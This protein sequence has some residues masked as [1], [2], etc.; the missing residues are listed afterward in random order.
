[1]T[2]LNIIGSDFKKRLDLFFAQCIKA[3]F[4]SQLMTTG[5]TPWISTATS[6]NTPKPP[7]TVV[8]Q[9]TP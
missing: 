6:S 2:N 8:W 4:P 7:S 5:M 9:V 1:M 3:G